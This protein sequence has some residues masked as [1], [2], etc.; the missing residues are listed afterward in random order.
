ML[1]IK[2]ALELTDIAT[3]EREISDRKRLRSQ[4]VGRLYPEILRNEE[5]QLN[6]L[7]RQIKVARN[8]DS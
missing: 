7:M 6:E 1:D 2:E 8:H 5:V 3:I 4:M